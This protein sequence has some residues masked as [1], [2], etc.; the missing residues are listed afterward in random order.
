M[1]STRMTIIPKSPF[2]SANSV[3][4][5]LLQSILARTL[6]LAPII[7]DPFS[8]VGVLADY[9]TWKRA[10][11]A[12][13]GRPLFAH[14]ERLWQAIQPSLAGR[15]ALSVL[16]FGVAWGYATQWWLSRLSHPDVEW[17]GFDTFTGVPTTW[18]R[19]GLTL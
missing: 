2:K 5:Q 15:G 19:A 10:R 9:A 14:R 6:N 4:R 16:E 12:G 1:P 13:K 11:L 18:D 8:Q 3:P 7:A 17:H